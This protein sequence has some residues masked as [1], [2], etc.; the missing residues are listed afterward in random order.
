MKKTR[1]FKQSVALL[2][3]ILLLVNAA[4]PANAFERKDHDEYMKQVMFK[5]FKNIDN[6]STVQDEINV[7]EC[8]AYLSVDQFNGS[9]QSDL[10]ILLRYGVK[11]IPT[12]VS[13]ISFNASGKTHRNYTHR[14]WDFSYGGVMAE[15]WPKRQSIL[16]N[17]VNTV[18]D[19]EGDTEKAEAFCELIYYIHV[20]G[21]HMDD[22]SWKIQNGLKMDARGR[23]DKYDIIHKLLDCFEV[24]FAD[25]R[26]THKYSHLMSE[27]EQYNSKFAKIVRSE[28]GINTD[29]KF[30]QHQEYV[31]NLM[32]VLTYYLPEML[33]EEGFFS[34]VFYK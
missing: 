30:E 20:L 33:K 12:S 9:G 16:L 15:I 23:A 25:Q 7:L 1:R 18:S 32:D 11:D 14:G 31:Q 27:L 10:D 26:H 3:V 13:E 6:D 2:Y 24:L 4:I 17:T 29:A 19:F 22:K 8:A 28:G 5:G 34:R 21:D